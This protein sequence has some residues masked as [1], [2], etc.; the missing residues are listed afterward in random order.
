MGLYNLPPTALPPA[1]T[2]VAR[3]AVAYEPVT[4]AV[5][6]SIASG[7]IVAGSRPRKDTGRNDPPEIA[8]R[9]R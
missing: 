7:A 2:V 1:V 8:G 6:V 9:A 5:K 4:E 3:P